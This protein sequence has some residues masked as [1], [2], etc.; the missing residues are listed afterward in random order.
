METIPKAVGACRRPNLANLY[1]GKKAS[2][3]TCTLGL[4]VEQLL[5]P[6]LMAVFALW[7]DN[8]AKRPF[9]RLLF[10]SN[11][12]KLKLKVPPASMCIRF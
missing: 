9:L 3:K 5:N 10:L 12:P 11:I 2:Q 4:P 7:P 6:K 8:S 1:S